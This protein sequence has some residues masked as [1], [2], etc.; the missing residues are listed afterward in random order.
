MFSNCLTAQ[1][2]KNCD[3]GE[4][5][6]FPY[7]FEDNG[8]VGIEIEKA[9]DAGCV[10]DGDT[11]Y[12]GS[13]YRAASYLDGAVRSPMLGKFSDGSSLPSD[14]GS[15]T[16]VG[17]GQIVWDLGEQISIDDFGA[18]P[19]FINTG[20]FTDNTDSVNQAAAFAK[21][22][23]ANLNFQHW[24]PCLYIPYGAYGITN[25][26]IGPRLNVHQ[27][28]EFYSVFP[29]VTKPTISIG[30]F[31]VS[32]L[33]GRYEGLSVIN[34][35]FGVAGYRMKESLEDHVG[36]R[37]FNVSDSFIHLGKN[38][39]AGHTIGVQYL[40]D[41]NLYCS[42]NRGVGGNFNTTRFGI[43]YRSRTYPSFSNENVHEG[44]NFT[45]TS[46][47]NEYGSASAVR[48]STPQINAGSIGQNNNR[49]LNPTF[50]M[51]QPKE[52]VAGDTLKES[53]RRFHNNVEW[54]VVTVGNALTGGTDAPTGSGTYTDNNGI[55]WQEVGVP[56]RCALLFDGAGSAAKVAG[57]R[58]ESGYGPVTRYRNMDFYFGNTH[59][60]AYDV[61]STNNDTGT[62]L[63]DVEEL[64]TFTVRGIDTLSRYSRR[65]DDSARFENIHQRAVFSDS[66]IIVNGYTKINNLI[67]VFESFS[68]N[69]LILCDG[70]VYSPGGARTIALL[71]D[72][73]S[74][75]RFRI[76]TDISELDQSNGRTRL[77]ALDENF[78]LININ[79]GDYQ[80]YL[81]GNALLAGPGVLSCNNVSRNVFGRRQNSDIRYLAIGWFG[82]RVDEVRID[83]TPHK[84]EEEQVLSIANPWRH[85]I[86]GPR[87]SLGKPTGGYFP[88]SGEL[89][90][91]INY[92]GT[93]TLGWRVVVTGVIA[94]NWDVNDVVIEG[95][96]RSNAG[97]VY[98]SIA[99]GSGGSAPN[100]LN[101]ISGNWRHI[102]NMAQTVSV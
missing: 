49:I 68:A 11:I 59:F 83:T 65:A 30:S 37:F 74:A 60:E 51:G 33:H 90:H 84:A 8:D 54:E 102:S 101:G 1:N 2:I 18:N 57:A 62:D 96:L 97:Q 64:N 99:S 73:N 31:S 35:T 14:K 40:A 28:G 22:R 4:V 24:R 87:H 43:D 92:N 6:Y 23:V 26:E 94:P 17:S 5:I 81:Q 9:V 50:Q 47:M 66:G 88:C 20:N 70:S 93:N 29:D 46:N 34:E 42:N 80:F 32:T 10:K 72:T 89:I 13:Y 61:I 36:I 91:N 55:V 100:H 27:R 53:Y 77:M 95:E 7:G 56:F 3:V 19:D 45:I 63:G 69:E 76:H 38:A 21:S 67:G 16:D 52:W 15:V 44:G 82:E 12:R 41:N 78:G 85:T 79:D 48:F 58:V 98:S 25:I 39:G 75:Q 86:D 71:I